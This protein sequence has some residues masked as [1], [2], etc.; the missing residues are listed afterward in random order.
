MISKS[1]TIVTT[2][3][4][5]T[6]KQRPKHHI[7]AHKKVHY[8]QQLFIFCTRT[9]ANIRIHNTHWR[10]SLS[11]FLFLVFFFQSVVFTSLSFILFICLNTCKW[12]ILCRWFFPLS[13]S[14]VTVRILYISASIEPLFSF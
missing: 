11:L 1:Y 14:A 5:K 3:E 8:L 6:K 12:A 10:A 4:S 2:I 7:N 13:F 9:H